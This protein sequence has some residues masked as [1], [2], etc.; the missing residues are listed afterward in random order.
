MRRITVAAVIVL[1]AMAATGLAMSLVSASIG[2]IVQLINF[3]FLE[4]DSIRRRRIR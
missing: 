4:A 1:I 2:I 3:R